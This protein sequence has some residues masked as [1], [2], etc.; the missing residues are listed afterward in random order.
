MPVRNRHRV[1]DYLI[2]D[3]E[4]GFTI[5]K[6]EA[7]KIWDGTYRHKRMYETRHPQEFVKA[8]RDPR[9]LDVVRPEPLVDA[10]VNAVSTLIGSTAV[11]TPSGPASHLFDPGIGEMKVGSTFVVR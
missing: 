2:R 3:D 8:K 4:S 5:Y 7:V 9:A 6:S 1:G 11:P 10:P